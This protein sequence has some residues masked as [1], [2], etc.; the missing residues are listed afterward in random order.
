V[1]QWLFF[2]NAWKLGILASPLQL[3]G[4]V[5]NNPKPSKIQNTVDITLIS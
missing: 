1:V 4:D 3:L 2:S 5:G